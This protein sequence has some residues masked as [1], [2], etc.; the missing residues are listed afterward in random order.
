MAT[1]APD[2]KRALLEKLLAHL[3]A[4]RA[5]TVRAHDDARIAATH[6]EAKP[7][8]DKDTRALEA[9][10]LAAGQAARV[11]ELEVAAK[12][13]GTMELRAFGASTPIQS[14]AIVTLEDDDGAESTFFVAPHGGGV[15]LEAE[16]RAFQVVTPQSPLGQALLGRTQGDVVELRAKGKVREMTILSV[17]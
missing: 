9:S 2:L 15:K 5:A 13:L 10:Y 16:G 3:D 4:E 7:E 17:E 12:V 11:A 8:N 1:R 14:T 6:A